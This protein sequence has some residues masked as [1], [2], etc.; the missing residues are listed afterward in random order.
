MNEFIEQAFTGLTS[1]FNTSFDMKDIEQ[2]QHSVNLLE[3]KKDEIADVVKNKKELAIKDQSFLEQ[4]LK[5]LIIGS[6][7]IL[8]KLDAEIITGSKSNY[9][10]AYAKMASS[11]TS[12]LK[13]LRELSV[14][15]VELEIQKQTKETINNTMNRATIVLDAS[16]LD[17]LI[18]NAKSNSQM[19]AIDANFTIED[20]EK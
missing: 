18:K 12:Q 10:D 16:A 9:Y 13:E 11:I 20:E 3:E 14:A 8:Q 15:V 17:L 5:S 6:R 4:E 7:T 2:I 1:A 19:N